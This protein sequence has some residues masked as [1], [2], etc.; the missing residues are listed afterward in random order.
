MVIVAP[1]A[2]SPSVH[3]NPLEHG[4]PETKVKPG[5]VGSSTCKPSAILGPALCTTTV[6]AMVDPGVAEA[7]PV[8][9]TDTSAEA[10]T[11]VVTVLELSPVSGSVT[12]DGAVA[13]A[14]LINEPP[15]TGAVP[16]IV[17]VTLPSAG[18]VVIVLATSLPLI[19]TVPHTAPPVAPPHVAM[20]LLIAAGTGSSR[21]VPSASLGPLLVTTTLY[22]IA[23]P[24]LT[25]AGPVLTTRRSACATTSL[26][27]VLVLLAVFGSSVGPLTVAVFVI[28]PPALLG[29][30][31]V[32][33]TLTAVDAGIAPIS[34]GNPPE[35]GALAE[36]NVSPDGV[37]SS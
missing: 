29:T 16:L 27:S 6:Y 21:V 8:L 24:A 23:P 15:V 33:V 10:V 14:V 11:V 18:S 3:G 28:V 31:N 37:G 20:R 9:T 30:A 22:E 36:T 17:K 32:A 7:G 25:D 35:H 1:A 19:V 13:V 2:V 5:G 4:V 12:P 26:S 34:H